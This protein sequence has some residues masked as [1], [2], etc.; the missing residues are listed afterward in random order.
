MNR[1]YKTNEADTAAQEST[2]QNKAGSID[3]KKCTEEE[4][5][6]EVKYSGSDSHSER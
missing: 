5:W 6:Q 2:L 3:L 1:I 4:F